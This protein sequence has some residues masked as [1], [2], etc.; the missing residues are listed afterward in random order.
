MIDI[1]PIFILVDNC[2][3]FLLNRSQNGHDAQQVIEEQRLLI[4]KLKAQVTFKD[5]RIQQ[6]EDHI[7]LYSIPM[8]SESGLRI[9]NSES[10]A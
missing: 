6:L 4:E 3:N 8:N 10:I 9:Q 2:G 1:Q 7:K 5:R